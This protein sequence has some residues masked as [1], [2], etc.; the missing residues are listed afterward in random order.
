MT[1]EFEIDDDLHPIDPLVESVE[2]EC[3]TCG[4]WMLNPALH[5][6]WHADT[7]SRF[8][9]IAAEARRYKS[10]PVYGGR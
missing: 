5:R 9:A 1:E 2:D 10:P 3:P 6:N 4:A 8:H 7:I